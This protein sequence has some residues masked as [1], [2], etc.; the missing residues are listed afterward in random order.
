MKDR[1]RKGSRRSIAAIGG[2]VILVAGSLAGCGK[3]GQDQAGGL[4]MEPV[5]G[6]YVETEVSL[7]DMWEDAKVRQIFRV[8]EQVHFL[9]QRNVEG[10]VALEEWSLG[11]NASFEEVTGNWLREVSF[12]WDAYIPLKLLQDQA[13][14]QYLY[15]CYPSE[16]EELYQGHLWRSQGDGAVEIT[17]GQWTASLEEIGYYVYPEDLAVTGSG[18][19]V[20]A[21]GQTLDTYLGQDGSLLDREEEAGTRDG[22]LYGPWME[23]VGDYV[24]RYTCDNRNIVTGIQVTKIGEKGQEQTIPFSQEKSGSVYFSVLPGGDM[25]AMGPDGLFFCQA[26]DSNWI[27]QMDGADGAMGLLDVWC[28]G[29]AAL[30]DGTVY[31]L[32]GS[33]QGIRLMQYRYDPDAVIQITETLRLYT[34]QESYLLQQ[35]AALYHRE[36]PEVLIQ[37]ESA[38]SIAE[39]H[40]GTPDYQDIFQKLNTE[41]MAGNGADILVMDHL[42]V[43]TYASKGLL[44]DLEGIVGP[45]EEDGTLLANITGEYRTKDGRRYVVP[46]QFGFTMAVGRGIPSRE[47]HSMEALAE[48]LPGKAVNCMGPQ[49]VE[50][51]VDKFYPYFVGE[52][53]KEKSLDKEALA[54]HLE[55]LKKIADNCGI[56]ERRKE[57]DDRCYNIWDMASHASLAFHTVNGFQEAMWPVSVAAYVKGEYTCFEEAYQ[58]KLEMGINSSSPNR[59]RAE[60]F[61][62]FALSGEVQDADYYEGFPVNA[63]SLEKL[64]AADRSNA[65]AYTSIDIGDGAADE[66]AILDFSREEAAGILQMC[67]SLHV[68]Y[69]EDK[70]IREELIL[71]LPGY[72]TGAQSLEETLGMVEKG[73][74]MYLA[75]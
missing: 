9:L 27:K 65:E 52:I 14:D 26:G 61:L 60:D 28:M 53:V 33:E 19:L 75:E 37:I 12:P 7:P 36:H 44:V 1:K 6:C 64:A 39:G 5:K 32:F 54:L 48:T 46:L 43:E 40:R 57:K 18:T 23:S 24:Y 62:R 68:R 66:L 45:M 73:L 20:C 31:G 50:E 25:V 49:T 2:S 11:E 63:H 29:M 41:L 8:E 17:P 47:M 71:A 4:S 15:A 34:V 13:G 38:W 51:L 10:N 72:L 30:P 42:D 35:A 67:R 59:E 58:P 56:L 3:A 21:M 16:G 55:Q 22:E 74:N 69:Q 70:K